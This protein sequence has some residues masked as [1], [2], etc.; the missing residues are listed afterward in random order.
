MV[1]VAIR[2]FEAVVPTAD[3]AGRTVD[4]PSPIEWGPDTAVDVVGLPKPGAVAQV[5][6]PPGV[7]TAVDT[8]PEEADPGSAIA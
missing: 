3:L 7:D 1:E 2:A 8:A 5:P 4:L 6:P